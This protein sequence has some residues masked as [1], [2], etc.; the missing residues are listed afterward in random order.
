M[1]RV[2]EKTDAEEKPV[3]E[4]QVQVQVITDSQLTNMKLDR[5][6]ELLESKK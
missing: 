4:A 6:I 3:Q 2:A 5:I 1:P